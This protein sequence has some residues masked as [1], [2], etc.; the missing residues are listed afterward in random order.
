[1][2]K[3]G[4]NIKLDVSKLDKSRFFKGE[5]G[6]YCDLTV[7]IDPDNPSEYGSHGL[8]TQSKKKDEGKDI[9][10]PIVGDAK[11]FWQEQGSAPQAPQAP[12]QAFAGATEIVD[13]DCPF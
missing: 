2:S 5:K 8:L 12:Q 3:I 4:V 13:S 11:V 6:N 9:R 7:F 10:L 1:M